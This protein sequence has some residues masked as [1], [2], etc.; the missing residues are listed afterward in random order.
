MA[1]TCRLFRTIAY[2]VETPEGIVALL[3][4]ALAESNESN[5]FCTA[6]VGILD[7]KSGELRYCNAGHNPPIILQPDG[8]VLPMKIVPNL[9]LGVWPG[10]EYQGESCMVNSGSTLFL[11]TDGVTE[12]ETC[13]NE[14]YGEQR[15]ISVLQSQTHNTPCQ[16]I[17][18]VLADIALHVKGADQNDDITILCCSIGELRDKD[19]CR[20]ITLCNKIEEIGRMSEFIDQLAEEFNLSPEVS[21]NVH[22]AL[23]E[24][25]TNVIMYAFPEGEEHEIMLTV[26]CAN[27]SLIFNVVDSGMEFDPTLQPD[28]DVTLSLEERPIG[29]LGIFLIRR[30]MQKVEYRRVDGKNILTM[31]KVLED[32]KSDNNEE[33]ITQ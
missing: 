17:D 14:L 22:L 6:F 8:N 23:E 21:F 32:N 11:Y 5:M 13:D 25:V 3:N 20:H 9:A 19:E 26:R 4:D 2:N 1:V 7:L 12:A 18:N 33:Y 27:N 30:I 15:L 24:A 31:V 28:A 16:I 29:G 10:F